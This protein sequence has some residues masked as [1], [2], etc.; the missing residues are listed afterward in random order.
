MLAIQFTF[1]SGPVRPKKHNEKCREGEVPPQRAGMRI[2]EDTPTDDEKR[3][4]S[5]DDC[6]AAA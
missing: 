1:Y 4:D 5:K 2:I 3:N 6:V